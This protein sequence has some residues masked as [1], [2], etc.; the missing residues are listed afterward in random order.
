M[1]DIKLFRIGTGT[2]NELTGTTDTI[3]KSVQILFEKES[4]S[5]AR[6][7]LSCQR[8]YDDEWRGASIRWGWLAGLGPPTDAECVRATMRGIRRTVGRAKVRK[9]PTLPGRMFGM[10]AAAPVTRACLR[11]LALLLIGFGGRAATFGAGCARP[12]RYRG[13]PKPGYWS[14][15]AVARRSRTTEP[16]LIVK[17]RKYFQ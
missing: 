1:S 6:R 9:P 17:D 3:E 2:V 7:A 11:D 14:R 8:V 13:K 12:Y 15:S 5:A 4:G 16:V 10:A